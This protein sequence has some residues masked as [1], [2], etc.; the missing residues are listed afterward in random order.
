MN[1]SPHSPQ[2]DASEVPDAEH[3]ITVRALRDL[4]PGL[5]IPH[6]QRGLVWGSSSTSALL[7]SL[8]WDTPCG[9]FV[10]WKPTSPAEHG[11]P[12]QPNG[13]RLEYLVVDGQQRIRCLHGALFGGADGGDST[14]ESLAQRSD[15]D[16]HPT[17]RI[18]CLN[19]TRLPHLRVH[20]LRPLA[21]EYALFV[22]AADPLEAN[23]RSP[24]R[25]SLI[26][27]A[28]L[29][30]G[31]SVKDYENRSFQGAITSDARQAL[32]EV[33][34]RA[35][36]IL[37]RRFF[38]VTVA[39]DDVLEIVSVY[40]RINSGGLRVET[41][42]RAFARLV[43]LD[44][45]TYQHVAEIFRTFH[46]EKGAYGRDDVM[47]RQREHNFGFKTFLR[48]FVQTCSYHFDRSVGSRG[49]SFGL[50]ESEDFARRLRDDAG[51]APLSHLWKDAQRCLLTTR[52][53]LV[54]KP[55]SCDELAFLP[56]VSSLAPFF[57]LLL[58]FEIDEQRYD[59]VLSWLLLALVLR[60]PASQ[61]EWLE[62]VRKVRKE[63]A[64]GLAAL[65]E[66]ACEADLRARDA[67]A[68]E[69]T[70][71][72]AN[73][74]QNRY[75]LLLYWLVRWKGAQDFSYDNVPKSSLAGRIPHPVCAEHRPEKQHI[76]PFSRLTPFYP[77]ADVR[78]GSSHPVNNIAN[79]TYISR[80]L[81]GLDALA[82][83]MIELERDTDE[84]LKKHFLWEEA[85]DGHSVQA[86]YRE[87]YRL[88]SGDPHAADADKV[89]K[90]YDRFCQR[91]R[92]LIREGFLAWLKSA[93]DDAWAALGAKSE[94]ELEEAVG[95]TTVKP[96]PRQ[97]PARQ[98]SGGPVAGEGRGG[99]RRTTITRKAFLEALESHRGPDAVQLFEGLSFEWQKLGLKAVRRETCIVF[100]MRNP[101]GGRSFTMH[102]VATNGRVWFHSLPHMLHD[103]EL[104]AELGEQYFSDIRQL[105]QTDARASDVHGKFTPGTLEAIHPRKE[106][107]C[108]LLKG[109][110]R[111][112]EEA[113]SN[114]VGG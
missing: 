21:K 51:T 8:Y 54:N 49:F 34:E 74:I 58:Q 109:T 108:A 7:E 18:W 90:A 5:G 66:L 82:H 92:A 9:S 93:R 52:R 99:G 10:L 57:Q 106:D 39:T 40:N 97:F 17:K 111:R 45:K 55:V 94:A 98:E 72:E 53:I 27:L 100:R 56:E 28:R 32:D 47:K 20:G 46:D 44:P 112:I 62:Q 76:I 79:F 107:F 38:R 113:A 61:R 23:E 64:N 114:V 75:V 67:L 70:L 4:V 80:E 16:E 33:Y 37:K 12:L 41:E 68:G 84:A 73:S 15:G 42:E 78:R 22:H 2:A 1:S 96:R 30:N 103:A 36:S 101:R 87:L 19:L 89:R 65:V 69:K 6:F 88:L 35:R 85:H 95:Q 13:N 59:P 14:V 91:R 29:L 77:Q 50:L 25:W 86:C 83:T 105:F 60:Q 71:Q 102:Q 110:M 24:L 31:E 63:R 26:P 11:D 104:P 43:S 48:T 3:I 81:N